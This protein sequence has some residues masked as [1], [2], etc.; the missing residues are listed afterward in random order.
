MGNTETVYIL[1]V[2]PNFHAELF[3]IDRPQRYQSKTYGVMKDVKPKL[4]SL[5]WGYGHTPVFKD[6][7]YSILAIGWGP[8]IQ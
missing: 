1:K 2:R 3:R 7:S 8:L 6:K 5:C 4:P